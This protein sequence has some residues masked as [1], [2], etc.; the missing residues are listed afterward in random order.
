MLL[1]TLIKNLVEHAEQIC[2][3]WRFIYT[4]EPKCYDHFTFF[5]GRT[6]MMWKALNVSGMTFNCFYG[7]T[8]IIFDLMF[9]CKSNGW[10]CNLLWLSAEF[11][12]RQLRASNY[13]N[14]TSHGYFEKYRVSTFTKRMSEGETNITSRRIRSPGIIK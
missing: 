5:K 1:V 6:W 12:T 8:S 10:W 3:D 2:T 13:E 9:T 14:R 7:G 11:I 4:Q